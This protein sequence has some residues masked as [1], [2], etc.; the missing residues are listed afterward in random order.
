MRIYMTGASCAG[1]TTLGQ[2]V[3]ALLGVRH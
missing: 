3:A 2:N 1:V